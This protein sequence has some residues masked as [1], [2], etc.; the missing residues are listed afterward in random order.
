MNL[1]TLDT[2][3]WYVVRASFL[4]GGIFVLLSLALAYF[5]AQPLWLLLAALV[6]VMFVLFALTGYCPGALLLHRLGVPRH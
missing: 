4:M 3:H 6:G 2:S 1:F 5:S